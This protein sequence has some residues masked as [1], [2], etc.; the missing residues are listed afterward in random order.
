MEEKEKEVEGA[1]VPNGEL[2][3]LG[4]GA[5]APKVDVVV[6]L[7]VCCAA[8]PNVRGGVL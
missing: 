2:L 4:G 7:D 6:G 1:V 3:T 5:G 8:L